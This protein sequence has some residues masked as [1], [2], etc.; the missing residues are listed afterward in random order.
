MDYVFG[1]F[2]GILL[3]STFWFVVYC[4]WKRNKPKVYPKVILPALGSGI[5]WGIAM[6]QLL[7]YCL[8]SLMFIVVGW[9][10]ANENL[11]LA[12]SFPIITTVSVY[13][14]TIQ[15]VTV[16]YNMLLYYTICYCT[17]QYV[18]VQYNM[19]LYCYCTVQY[20]TVL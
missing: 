6:G 12:V 13:Y 2:T 11:S 18:T 9:F 15:Y 8:L 3:A 7:V 17:V 14:C 20:V 16:L 1:H 4:I 5:L 19:L 10:I